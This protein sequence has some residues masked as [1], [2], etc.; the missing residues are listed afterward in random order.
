[1]PF[2]LDKVNDNQMVLSRNVNVYR[3]NAS[4][5]TENTQ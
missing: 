4:E 1:M 5:Q 2:T 3:S